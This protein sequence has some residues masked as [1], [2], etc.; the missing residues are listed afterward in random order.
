MTVHSELLAGSEPVALEQIRFE[1]E[2][3]SREQLNSAEWGRVRSY[4][5]GQLM[6][7][8]DGPF[9]LMD[10]YW[11]L[12]SYGLGEDNL[13]KY[14]RTL[15]ESSPS[16]LMQVAAEYLHADRLVV[17]SAGPSA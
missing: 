9:A 14:L 1:M 15:D 8:L 7:G 12:E 10:R 13:R 16:D 17:A 6:A 5:L 2:R 11:D 4:L 3:L